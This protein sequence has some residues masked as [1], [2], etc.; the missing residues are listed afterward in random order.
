MPWE[1]ADFQKNSQRIHVANQM[2]YGATEAVHSSE[3]EAVAG[4]ELVLELIALGE[5]RKGRVGCW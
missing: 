4:L 2:A 1:G 3:Y 5:I